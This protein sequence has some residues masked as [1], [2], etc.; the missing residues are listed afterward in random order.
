[1]RDIYVI[2]SSFLRKRAIKF[3]GVIFLL[4]AVFTG[5][6]G[7]QVEYRSLILIPFFQD[8]FI[9]YYSSVAVELASLGFTILILD[10]LYEIRDAESRKENLILQLSSSNNGLALDACRNLLAIG[11]FYDGSLRGAILI[12]ANLEGAFLHKADLAKARLID[13]NMTKADMTSANLY[14]ADLQ[15]ANISKA[16]I[17]HA[18]FAKANLSKSK[19]HNCA[20]LGVNFEQANLSGADLREVVFSNSDFR[21]AILDHARIDGSDFTSTNITKEQILSC[22]SYESTILPFDLE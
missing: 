8:V 12:D 17:S 7:Y 5:W 10:F 6:L 3:I 15:N 19:L 16:D 11:A 18:S 14:C 2:W 21:L 13:A 9:E 4:F 20:A 22:R 1:M